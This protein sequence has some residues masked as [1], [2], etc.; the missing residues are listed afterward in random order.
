M[1]KFKDMQLF[2]LVV[3]KGNFAQAAKAAQLTPAMVGRRIAAM[4]KT[5][6]FVLFNRNTR[7]MHLTPNGKSYYEGCK[8]ILSD[9]AE[10]EDSL[11]ANHQSNPK[12]LIRISAPD[13]LGNTLLDAIVVFKQTYPE[14][15]FDLD[16]S[17]APQDLLKEQIDLSLRLAF[18]LEDS[19][20]VATRL[21]QSQF[22]LFASH[23]YLEKHGKP[24]TL[25]DL[26]HHACLSMTQS[27]DGGYWHIMK[28]G[29]PIHYKQQWALTLS[30]TP[31]LI[32]AVERG[33]GLAMIPRLFVANSQLIELTDVVEF[34]E[35]TLY[36]IY[37]S[38]RHLPFR[39]NLFLQHL[40][41]WFASKQ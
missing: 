31:S 15:R 10:L 37:P 27:K 11:S 36:G 30:T 8:Q 33:L 38:R 23:E 6:G 18:E 24:Q 9:V 5:L 41:G 17:N 22:G 7:Q 12:G 20:L 4:E 13:A 28:Q 40:K 25:E 3:E 1:S 14:I 32:H 29:K 26:Q 21:L 19:S 39:V 35:L 34:P 2:A 16:L